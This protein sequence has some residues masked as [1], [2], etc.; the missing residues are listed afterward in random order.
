MEWQP[1]EMAPKDGTP[2][3]VHWLGSTISTVWPSMDRVSVASWK[4]NHPSPHW[5][6]TDG[7]FLHILHPTHWMPLP[8]PPAA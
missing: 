2:I 3:L 5:A 1:I 8:N 7:A 6:P 4:A